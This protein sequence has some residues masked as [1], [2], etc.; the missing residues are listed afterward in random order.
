MK[1]VLTRT[2]KFDYFYRIPV[3]SVGRHFRRGQI[4]LYIIDFE[5]FPLTPAHT[6]RETNHSLLEDIA[7]VEKKSTVSDDK[8]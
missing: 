4:L 1:G 2:S 5:K 8:H 3:S 6:L 7:I